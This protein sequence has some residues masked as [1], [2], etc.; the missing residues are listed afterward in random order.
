LS[1]AFPETFSNIITVIEKI[2]KKS[3]NSDSFFLG[4]E[5]GIKQEE[6]TEDLKKRKKFIKRIT[7]SAALFIF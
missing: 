1:I 5:D 2:S 3:L 4:A 6:Q 7:H